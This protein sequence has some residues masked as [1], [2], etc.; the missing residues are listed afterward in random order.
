MSIRDIVCNKRF[1]RALIQRLKRLNSMKIGNTEAITKRNSF[2]ESAVLI[3]FHLK[4][5]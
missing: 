3:E 2:F 4:S 1:G 5:I